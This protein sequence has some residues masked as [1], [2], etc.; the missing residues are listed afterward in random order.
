MNVLALSGSNSAASMNQELML[1]FSQNIV[2][3][4]PYIFCIDR[5]FR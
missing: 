3:N 1:S 2:S 5:F 4:G